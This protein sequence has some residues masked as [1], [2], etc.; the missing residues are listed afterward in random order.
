[1]ART[2]WNAL[3]EVKDRRGHKIRGA[4]RHVPE[5]GENFR[6]DQNQGCHK[7]LSLNDPWVS[8]SSAPGGVRCK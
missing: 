2:L 4:G 8:G 7:P 1:M 3:G 5:A 6:E